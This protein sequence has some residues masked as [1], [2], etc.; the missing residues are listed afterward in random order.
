MGSLMDDLKAAQQKVLD[1][2]LPR[3]K[4][5][6]LPLEERWAIYVELSSAGLLPNES[7]GDGFLHDLQGTHSELTQYDDFNNDRYQ[8]VKFT[9]MYQTMLESP[10]NFEGCNIDGWREKVLEEGYG[11]F[12]YDW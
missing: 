3:M 9:D 6:S 12:E 1:E 10:E 8:T 4:D 2:R 11:S 7:Y 5:N